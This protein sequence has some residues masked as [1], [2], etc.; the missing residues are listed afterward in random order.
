MVIQVQLD[1]TLCEQV[2]YNQLQAEHTMFWRDITGV[3][4]KT[5]NRLVKKGY[6]VVHYSENEGD[7]RNRSWSIK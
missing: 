1:L 4:V 7:A 3:E 2:M 5:L 6:A